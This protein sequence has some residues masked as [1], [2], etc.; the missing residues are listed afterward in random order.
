M[1]N[2]HLLERHISDV[3]TAQKGKQAGG[4]A[5]IHYTSTAVDKPIGAFRDT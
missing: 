1:T 5:T 2:H 3:G 4:A